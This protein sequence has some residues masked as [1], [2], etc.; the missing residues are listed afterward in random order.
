VFIPFGPA[1]DAELAYRRDDVAASARRG[2]PHL[3]PGARPVAAP[4]AAL[5]SPRTP[6]NETADCPARAA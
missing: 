4:A 6:L 1:L 5:P 2:R 3:R